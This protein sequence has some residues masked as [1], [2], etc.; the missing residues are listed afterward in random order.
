MIEVLI[1]D[2]VIK[3]P[4]ELTIGKYQKIQ[5]NP[6]KYNNHT[7]ILGLY[8]DLSPTELKNLP[9]DQIKF[10][11]G[12]LS[13]HLLK[14]KTDQLTL[15]FEI[16]GVT[17]GLENDWSKLTWGQWV[18]LEVYSQPDTIT[19]NIHKIL[20][21]LYRPIIIEKGTKYTLEKF[22]YAKLE[23]RQQLFQEKLPIHIW[24]GIGVFFLGILRE[25]TERMQT[26]MK[27]RMKIEKLTRPI[28]KILPRFLH[29]KYVRD[30]I[31]T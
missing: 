21:I 22:D 4:T 20:A 14:E 11:E 29:P 24:F 16:D 10:V 23:E 25:F 31:L 27:V 3:V 28:L 13:Q 1:D 9:V 19:E 7:E 18:D 2:Q 26:S 6:Q 8:L 30:S 5:S 12:I 15:T 17:Y